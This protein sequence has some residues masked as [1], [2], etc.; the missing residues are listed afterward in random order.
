MLL[1]S[2]MLSCIRMYFLLLYFVDISLN[3]I[4]RVGKSYKILIF[5]F[6]FLKVFFLA[7][8]IEGKTRIYFF[9]EKEQ[10]CA[11]HFRIIIHI[12]G[13]YV[14]IWSLKSCE[15]INR[16]SFKLFLESFTFDIFSAFIV[17]SGECP[18]EAL[19]YPKK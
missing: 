13:V 12:H 10:I 17:A 5:N 9:M 8:K 16:S 15:V 19:S 14:C 7:M 3:S 11:S 18:F 4:L 6:Y 2:N 1:V